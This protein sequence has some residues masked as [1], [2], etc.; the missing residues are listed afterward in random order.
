MNGWEPAFIAWPLTTAHVQILV[1]FAVEHN[2]CI[3]VAGTGHDFL[4]RHSCNQGLMIRTALL[5]EKNW[6]NQN[7][8]RFGAGITFAEAHQSASV[9]NR[10]VASGWSISVGIAGWSMGGGHGP[11]ARGLGIGVDQ[12]VEIEIVTANASV[13]TLNAG[14]TTIQDLDGTK[15]HSSS[16]DFFWAIR[17]GGASTW[18]IVTA[19]TMHAYPIPSGGLT[20]AIY[21]GSLGNSTT[22][23]SKF[24]KHFTDWSSQLSHLWSGLLFLYPIVNTSNPVMPVSFTVVVVYV[25]LGCDNSTNFIQ[26]WQELTQFDPSFESIVVNFDNSWQLINSSDVENIIPVPWI[27]PSPTTGLGGV[28]SVLVESNFVDTLSS[29]FTA[30]FVKCLLNISQCYGY[31]VY[32]DLTDNS[33]KDY[34]RTAVAPGMYSAVYHLV[35]S[36]LDDIAT[37]YGLGDYSYFSESAF[38][39]PKWPSR[40]WGMDKYQRLL[41]I[42]QSVDPNNIFWCNHC[43]GDSYNQ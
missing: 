37:L 31:Q 39:N 27:A 9:N 21:T 13:L 8:V 35:F 43:I 25:Y 36:G 11:F 28:P 26:T 7:S 34:N 14:G 3:S 12:I 10:M 41:S 29:L 42:K 17:G 24:S 33:N 15:T 38:E 1:Q 30:S 18:G 2:L 5:K 32:H 19:Y 22:L 4:N 6:D 40:Y 16:T 20:K 23:V